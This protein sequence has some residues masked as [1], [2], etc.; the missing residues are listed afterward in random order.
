M[1]DQKKGSEADFG[2]PTVKTLNEEITR[3][4]SMKRDV[5]ILTLRKNEDFEQI[6]L[7]AQNRKAWRKISEIV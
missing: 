3:A 7:T 1:T 4:K 2:K 6:R 5:P